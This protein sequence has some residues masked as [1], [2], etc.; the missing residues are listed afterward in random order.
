MQDIKYS[1]NTIGCNVG[2]VIFLNPELYTRPNLYQAVLA[3]EMKHTSSFK[4]E[5]VAL[6]LFND[7]L[8]GHKL[9]FYRFMISHPRTLLGFLPVTKIGKSWC[10]DIEIS[11]AWLMS[12]AFIWFLGANL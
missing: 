2:G 10:W 7:D 12:I 4:R 11:V 6:D 3:H 8:K 5:D 9:E 1:K